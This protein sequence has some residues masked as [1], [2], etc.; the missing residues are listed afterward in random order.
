MAGVL[1]LQKNDILDLTKAEPGLSKVML[2]AGWDVV[3][4]QDFS[5]LLKI[6]T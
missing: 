6:T 4:N 5:A 1:N 3:K 2:G